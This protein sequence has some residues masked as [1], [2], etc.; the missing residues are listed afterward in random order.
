MK[1]APPETNI[2]AWFKSVPVAMPTENMN[3]VK[4]LNCKQ[5]HTNTQDLE[6][7]NDELAFS[8]KRGS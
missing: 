6:N 5:D 2:R 8:V 7:E 3:R 4:Y 1:T